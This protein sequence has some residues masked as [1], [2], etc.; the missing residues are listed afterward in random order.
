MSM[1]AGMARM[2]RARKD[3]L[4]D[5]QRTRQS[6]RDTMADRFEKTYLEPT[7]ADVRQTVE[8]MEQLSAML[9]QA[10]RDCE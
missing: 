9:E 6:W 4:A 1:G 2:E 5:W 8:A 10:R 3:L 7:D